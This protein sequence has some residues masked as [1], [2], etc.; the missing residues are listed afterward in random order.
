MEDPCPI[1]GVKIIYTQMN[2]H[3][4]ECLSKEPQ[5]HNNGRANEEEENERLFREFLAKENYPVT[6]Q[7]QDSEIKCTFCKKAF[8]IQDFH[9][10]DICGHAYCRPCIHTEI[11]KLVNQSKCSSIK[12]WDMNCS[13]PLTQFDFKELLTPKEFELYEKNSLAEVFSNNSQYVKCPKP[14]CTNII[15]RLHTS[16]KNPASPKDHKELYRFRCRACSTEFCSSCNT[17]PYHEGY[18]C[19]QFQDF[20]KAKHCRF[21]NCSL[22]DNNRAPIPDNLKNELAI[23]DVCN[24]PDC[25]SRRDT[26]CLKTFPCGHFCS[27]IRDEATCLPCLNPKCRSEADFSQNGDSFCNICWVEGLSC[28]PTVQLKCGHMFHFGCV[29]EQV[30]KKWSTSNIT[31]GFS[32]CSLCHQWID[33]ISLKPTLDPIRQLYD[34]VKS[35]AMQ[36]LKFMNLEKAKEIVTEGS[37][38]YNKPEAYALKSFCYYPCFKCKKP[39]F[40]GLRECNRVENPDE[41]FNPEELVCGACSGSVGSGQTNCAKH[42]TDYIEWKCRFC[43][44]TACWYCWGSTHF[45]DDCHKIASTIAKKDKSLLPACKCK[46]K[47]PPNGDE[48]CFG[49]SLCR[50]HT[51]DF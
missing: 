8:P 9:F 25:V 45:C 14:E 42:G 15:E 36:R 13:K 7:Q 50:L 41:K 32:E 35:K 40:G 34:E 48:Y 31:F 19:Q 17:I 2:E 49:C 10:L 20:K 37:P 44:A 28:A 16:H 33:H 43:C 11:M 39:Y 46:V 27:G 12:C 21:C 18:N 38:F 3:V 22:K 47:H 23:A 1:C 24:Q 29:K 5:Q 26:T 6:H 30:E 51:D 4:N